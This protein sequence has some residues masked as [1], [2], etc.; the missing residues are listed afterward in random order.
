MNTSR[1]RKKSA[2]DCGKIQEAR[3]SNLQDVGDGLLGT[4]ARWV[5]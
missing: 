3:I 5:Y 2:A 1:V 4:P